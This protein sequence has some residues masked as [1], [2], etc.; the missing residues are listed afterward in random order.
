ML[1]VS[2]R[3]IILYICFSILADVSVF[4]DIRSLIILIIAVLC[5][6]D[7]TCF[8]A[9]C[10]SVL[11]INTVLIPENSLSRIICV[12]LIYKAMS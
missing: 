1:F 12:I 11:T 9:I 2:G 4:V 3:K 10:I 8:I 5:D 7:R 6:I